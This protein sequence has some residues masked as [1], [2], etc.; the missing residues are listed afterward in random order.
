MDITGLELISLSQNSS[1]FIELR[2][3]KLEKLDGNRFELYNFDSNAVYYQTDVAY[4]SCT[5]VYLIH[6]AI[7]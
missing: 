4:V 1:N 6:T 3:M 2:K 7:Q 5:F